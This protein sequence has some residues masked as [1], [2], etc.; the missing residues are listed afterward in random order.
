MEK[1]IKAIK[2]KHADIHKSLIHMLNTK[3]LNLNSS[4]NNKRAIKKQ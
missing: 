4:N 1:W 2:R 3:K